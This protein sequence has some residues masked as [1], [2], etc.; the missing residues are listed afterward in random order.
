MRRGAG[1][2]H[3]RYVALVFGES[4]NDHDVL[5]EL[6]AALEP[7]LPRLSPRRTP[8]ILQREGAEARRRKNAQDVA[9]AIEREGKIRQVLF[10]VAHQD[11]DAVEP[12]H[13]EVSE[14]IERGLASVG[15]PIVAAAPAYEME[16]WLYQWPDA[17]SGVNRA[18]RRL[19]IVAE[20]GKIVRAKQQLIRELRPQGARR[21]PDYAESDAARIV[22]KAIEM[23]ELWEPKARAK[24]YVYFVDRLNA[25]ARVISQR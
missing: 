7:E 3:R 24:S 2:S 15:V 5:R 8:L 9:R 13:L 10:V 25:V 18:W 6:V 23:G 14:R 22:R 11:C 19:R 12:A 16:A 4:P 17:V 1:R 21:T 20:P